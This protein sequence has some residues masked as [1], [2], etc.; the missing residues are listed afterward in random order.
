MLGQYNDT[1]GYSTIGIGYSRDRG[2]VPATV[3]KEWALQTYDTEYGQAAGMVSQF[4]TPAGPD[5][6]ANEVRN[7]VLRDMEFNLMRSPGTN[8]GIFKWPKFRAAIQAQDWSTATAE[9]QNTP[10]Y[11]Q[12][13][14]RSANDVALILNPDPG[15][16][17]A[18]AQQQSDGTIK[19]TFPL[20]CSDPTATPAGAPPA[21]AGAPTSGSGAPATGAPAAAA[22]AGSSG[23]PAP[24]ADA[25]APA[26]APAAGADT[27]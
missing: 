2:S 9:M 3:T 20:F 12:V 25:A 26:A 14:Q 19:D 23:A 18:I 4:A 6:L 1:L 11:G 8:D 27:P 10:W 16:L 7:V 21:P 24:A 13:G 15:Q 22:P 5:P 17:A